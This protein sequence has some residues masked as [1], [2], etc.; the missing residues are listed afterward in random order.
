MIEQ[1]CILAGGMGTRLADL[2]KHTP[3]PLLDVAGEPFLGYVIWNLKRQGINRI[4]FS[5]GYLADQFQSIF[6]NGTGFGMN[7]E[8][9]VEKEPLGTGGGLKRSEN[10]LDDEFI[11]LNGDTIFDINYEDLYHGLSDSQP[12]SVA[13][14]KIEDAS[15]YGNVLLKNG[16]VKQFCEKAGAAGPGLIS[17]GV[18]AMKKSAL[19][20]LTPQ[21]CSIEKDMFPKLVER[22]KVAGQ[23]FNGF[24]LDIGIP[25][26]YKAAQTMLPNW[27]KNQ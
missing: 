25:E 3:K 18:Y 20:F 15:R 10:S 9:V 12:V 5:I 22:G 11:V 7:F 21:H 24:F 13:L 8:Y 2:T 27:K 19:E 1:A 26:T 14:H 23:I 6:G 4:V 17:G 16:I